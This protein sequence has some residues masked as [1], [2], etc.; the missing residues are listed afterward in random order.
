[1]PI[2]PSDKIVNLS[3]PKVENPKALIARLNIP[4]S[5]SM[6]KEKLGEA[7]VPG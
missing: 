5:W 7:A 4:V 3:V 1:M 6:A 2:L